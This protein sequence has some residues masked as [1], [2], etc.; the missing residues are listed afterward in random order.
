MTNDLA[1]PRNTERLERFQSIS[2]GLYW[3]ALC[4]IPEFVITEGMVLLIES[5]RYV[6]DAPHTIIVRA[7]PLN[8]GKRFTVTLT[9]DDGTEYRTY[10]TCET[11]RFLTED[12]LEKFEFE[13]DHEAIRQRET[14]QIQADIMGIQNE[15]AQAQ[16]DPDILAK[17]VEDKLNEKAEA[18]KSDAAPEDG[19]KANLPALPPN[20][21]SQAAHGTLADIIGS[22][23][24]TASVG[25]LK[26]AA[27]RQHEVA[28]IRANWLQEKTG[29]IGAKIGALTPFYKEQAAAALART[30]DVREYV[31]KLMKGIASLDLYTGA[32]VIVDTICEGP[33]APSDVPLTCVQR[34]LM[35]EEELAIWQDVDETF[36]HRDQK[37]FYDALGTF[38][39]LVDQVF[40]TKRCIVLMATTNRMIDY[41]DPLSSAANNEAN[42]MV[43]LMVRDGGNIYRVLSSVETHLGAGR[44][45]PSKDENDRIFQGIDGS[46]ITLNDVTY[47]DRLARHEDAA[48]HYK[49]FLILLCGLDHRLDLFGPFHDQPKDFT[50]VTTAFQEKYLR[51][52]HDEDG[53]GMLPEENR[54]DF[55]TYIADLN[56]TLQSGSRVLCVW[57]ALMTPDTSGSTC[58]AH[59]YG[60]HRGYDW[61]YKPDNDHDVVIARRAGRNIVVKIHV[62]G[63]DRKWQKRDFEATVRLP[64]NRRDFDEWETG[65]LPFL[66]LDMA[67]PDQLEWYI[68]NRKTRKFHLSYIK[69]F[70]RAVAFLRQERE[71]ESATRAKLLD[72]LTSNHITT[73][74]EAH[75]IISRAIAAWRAANRGADL[76]D[77]GA[78]ADN[79]K[80]W[81]A[82]LDQ[83][84]LLAGAGEQRAE[85]ILAYAADNGM[86]PLRVSLSGNGT[87]ILYAAPSPA[88]RDD[89]AEPFVWVHRI[90]TKPTK[91]GVSE[92]ARRWV[93]LQEVSADETIIRQF[94]E[95]DEWTGKRSVFLSP[96]QKADACERTERFADRIATFAPGAEQHTQQWEIEN[97]AAARDEQMTSSRYVE[98]PSIAVPLALMTDGD[99][100]Y[101]ICAYTD[102]PEAMLYRHAD[103]SM[104]AHIKSEFIS[105]YKRKGKAAD[106]F[107]AN[108]ANAEWCLITIGADNFGSNPDHIYFD[109]NTHFYSDRTRDSLDPRLSPSA[110]K[111]AEKH[112][113][114]LWMP[115]RNR[116]SAGD[117]T[118]DG[119]LGLTMPDGFAPVSVYDVSITPKDESQSG[120]GWIDIYPRALKDYE[121]FPR[122][123]TF[124]HSHASGHGWGDRLN[125]ET[126]LGEAMSK[127]EK[128]GVT[129]V[130]PADLPH[131]IT[132]TPEGVTRIYYLQKEATQ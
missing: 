67:D 95:A 49:R 99:K 94:P 52:I 88:E 101:F 48:L 87:M 126:A 45:F 84:Y 54:P 127:L 39:E 120:Y 125:S 47:T 83:M 109:K 92:T 124:D 53:E 12:F 73:A 97:W 66:C 64:I 24:T 98:N 118:A 60:S 23:I 107:E 51:F 132:E 119:I 115:E 4:D 55:Q 114:R 41:G 9:K 123:G 18:E 91:A 61:L 113:D 34:K 86:I 8:Y 78:G 62:S 104:R 112:G 38:P 75:D 59:S 105:V 74:A 28:T 16:S 26:A 31:T 65:S 128:R 131:P 19:P 30:E 20:A 96:K 58:F 6:D 103:E 35:M 121:P 21:L 70:K 72:A 77:F 110:A 63:E 17:I 44:L 102:A 130:Q 117:L 89:R 85:A 46:R 3:R 93:I 37:R 32:D 111:L 25:A 36:D 42:R 68:K 10:V 56:S 69:T 108:A 14:A 129:I 15:L 29:E 50:F 22:G 79:A 81:K 40:P 76:P 13:P 106:R 71:R 11:H 33:S 100:A 2:S 80:T 122:R 82:L 7:H 116:T 57:S 90:A 1:N 27:S 43:C 5:I